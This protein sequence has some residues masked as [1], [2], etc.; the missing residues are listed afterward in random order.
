MSTCQIL[1]KLI[2]TSDELLKLDFAN[3]MIPASGFGDLM[4]GLKKNKSV[5]ELDLSSNNLQAASAVH[6]GTYL[7]FSKSLIR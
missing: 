4:C 3:C 7:R 1:A 6:I 2:S 5:K